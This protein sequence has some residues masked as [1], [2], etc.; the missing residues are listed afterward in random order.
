MSYCRFENTFNDLRDCSA[1]LQE[2]GLEN[3]SDSEKEFAQRLI[4]LCADIADDWNDD[5]E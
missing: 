5:D 4:A 1:A 3:L 2:N